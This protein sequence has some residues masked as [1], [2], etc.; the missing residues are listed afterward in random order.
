MIG[1]YGSDTA[2]DYVIWKSTD[3]GATWAA[4]LT[5]SNPGTVRHFHGIMYVSELS[6]W[7]AWSGDSDAQVKWYYST[8]DGANW[9]VQMVAASQ[10]YRAVQMIYQSNGN[11]KVDF[12]WGVDSNTNEVCSP[13]VYAAPYDDLANVRRL[14]SVPPCEV[15][16]ISSFGPVIVCATY[17]GGYTSPRNSIIYGSPNGG[18]GWEIIALVPL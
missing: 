2:G 17:A 9:T 5:V 12:V 6:L 18:K 1:E 10:L 11:G 7:V 8:D 4:S 16:A 15:W 13:G 3:Y 14:L